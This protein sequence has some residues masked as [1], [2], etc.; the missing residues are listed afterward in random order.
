MRVLVTGGSGFLGSHLARALQAAGHQVLA[1]YHHHAERVPAGIEGVL[2]DLRNAASMAAAVRAAR[3]ESII[4]AAA[5]PDLKHCEDHPDLA[6]RV[7]EEGA[8]RL[9]ELGE[10]AGARFVFISTDQVFDG[11]RGMYRENDPPN[12]FTVYGR[13][14]AAA[15]RG[16]RRAQPRALVVRLA[17]L[18]GQSPGGTRSC[19]E[20]ILTALAEHERP[21]LFMDEHRSPILD[22]DAAGAIID[23]MRHD[24]LKLIHLGGPDRVSRYEL[25]VMLCGAFKL[26]RT[27]LEVARHAELF[28]GPRRPR[29]VSLDSAAARALLKKRPRALRDGL[30]RLAARRARAGSAT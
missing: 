19:T 5:M 26:D 4:H 29:D 1:T 15:E 3:A 27:H 10:E 30:A 20:Q 6:R 14:K 17:L 28:G 22:E 12:P 16:V 11:E 7:N 21:R 23:L 9:A 8:V 2:M 13:T 24:D 18:Y 25:G